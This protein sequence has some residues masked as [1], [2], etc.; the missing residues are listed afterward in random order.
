MRV[1]FL[2]LVLFIS[3]LWAMGNAAQARMGNQPIIDSD[4]HREGD[5]II[6]V[7][8][9]IYHEARGQV[10]PGLLA[11]ALV[12][13]NRV[14]SPIYPN[15]FCKVVWQKKFWRKGP[16]KNCWKEKRCGWSPQFSWTTDG[17]PDYVYNM[18]AW[19]KALSYAKLVVEAHQNGTYIPDITM[20]AMW[21][22]RIEKQEPVKLVRDEGHVLRW[23]IW[24]TQ[25]HA[26]YWMDDYYPT[27]KIGDHTFYARNEEAALSAMQGMM[28]N[29]TVHQAEEA[30]EGVPATVTVEDQ[31]GTYDVHTATEE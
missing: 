12:T 15:D 11:V 27:V 5:P 21:Y 9:N 14:E 25:E 4:K 13:K 24:Q 17:R 19:L 22:H 1:P 8:S 3:F 23:H 31:D 26:P 18:D 6:C 16:K 20:G 10:E 30:P 7:A 2:P 29:Y 28:V